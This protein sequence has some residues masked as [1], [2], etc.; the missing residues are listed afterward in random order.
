MEELIGSSDS[1]GFTTDIV[2]YKFTYLLMQSFSTDEESTWG[3]ERY[4]HT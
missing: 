2:L 4:N 1:A 3:Y